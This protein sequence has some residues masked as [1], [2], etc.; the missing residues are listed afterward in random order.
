MSAS[1]QAEL[2]LLSP[3]TIEA[4]PRAQATAT[5]RIVNNGS[6]P[7]RVRTDVR[8]PAGWGFDAMPQNAEVAPGASDTVFVSLLIPTNAAATA[9]P[10][11]VTAHDDASGA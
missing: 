10:V 3:T 1:A 9:Y 5:Y 7:I 6:T 8:A 11:E 2:T 4:L